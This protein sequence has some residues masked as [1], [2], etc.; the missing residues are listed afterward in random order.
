M[1]QKRGFKESFSVLDK[2]RAAVLKKIARTGPFIM[3]SPVYV[4]IRCGNP[5]CKC[6]KDKDARHTKLHLTWADSEGTGTQYVPVA[7]RKE[8]LEWVE[9]YWIVKEHMKDM[10]A[11]SRKMIHLYVRTQKKSPRQKV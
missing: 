9:N 6:S 8:V 7:L 1:A 10:T 5:R 11:L 3:A 2:R 4:K